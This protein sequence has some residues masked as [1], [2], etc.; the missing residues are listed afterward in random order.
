[1]ASPSPSLAT[2]FSEYP[3][4][5]KP[6][7]KG[8]QLVTS[9]RTPT[10]LVLKLHLPAQR[11]RDLMATNV[12]SSAG[13]I[14]SSPPPSSP[15]MG[16]SIVDSSKLSKK[17]SGPKPKKTKFVMGDDGKPVEVLAVSLS[18]PRLG[19]K[20]NAGAINENLRNL[21]R[22]GKPCR[23]W[24]KKSLTLRTLYGGK[25]RTPSWIGAEA[26]IS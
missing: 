26:T 16:P 11:L 10:S 13:S 7:K 3:L 24:H 17:K 23:R 15:V 12:V 14:Q 6:D 1:M 9:Q 21:D 19:P 20:S 8:S 4:A 18:G 2:T 5:N 25:W 22:S